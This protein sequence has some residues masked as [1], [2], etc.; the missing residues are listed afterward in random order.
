M[1][2]ILALTTVLILIIIDQLRR[3][4]K[5]APDIQPVIVKRYHHPGHTW[6]RETA[7]GD[8]LIGID[9]FAQSLIGQ[10]EGFELPRLLKKVQQGGIAM[11]I[12]HGNRRVPIVSP[13]SGRVIEK[14]EM[15]KHEPWLVNTA[16]YGD[17]WILRVRPGRLSQQLNNLLTGKSAAQ[18]LDSM[19]PRLAAL[20][21]GTPGLMYQDGGMLMDNLADR[22]SDE[23]WERV[24]E[25]FFLTEAKDSH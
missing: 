14:N 1:S 24:V 12:H 15:V 16:P 3:S 5:R 11:H 19:R 10:I 22:C 17:G 7:D 18:W 6:V 8:V 20:F 2:I 23:E 4:A 13:V 9:D 21:S 25:V